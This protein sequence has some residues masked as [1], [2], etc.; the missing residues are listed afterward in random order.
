MVSH[1]RSRN[2][3]QRLAR[4]VISI[5]SQRGFSANRSAQRSLLRYTGGDLARRLSGSDAPGEA[6][7]YGSRTIHY[8]YNSLGFRGGEFDPNARVKIFAFGCSHTCGQALDYDDA[9]PVQFAQLLGGRRGVDEGDVC[10]MNFADGGA[11]ADHVARVLISQCSAVKPDIVLVTFP[12]VDRTEL[13]LG[14]HAF[15]IGPWVNSASTTEQISTLATQE[16]RQLAHDAVERTR[17]YYS[18]G[19][20]EFFAMNTLRNILLVQYFCEVKGIRAVASLNGY[21][22]TVRRLGSVGREFEPLLREIDPRFL[23]HV[24]IDAEDMCTDRAADEFHPGPRTHRAFAQEMLRFL[25][26]GPPTSSP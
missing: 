26:E 13:L 19:S 3:S 15:R 23:S 4:P 17:S 14:G 11:S 7:Q 25:D 2:P 5:V 16:L 21:R 22:S 18:F 8:R 6:V 20:F 9:W 1:S 24:A 10:L 12:D